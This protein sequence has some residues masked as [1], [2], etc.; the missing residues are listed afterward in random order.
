M[1]RQPIGGSYV[2]SWKTSC[3]PRAVALSGKKLIVS[4]MYSST[5]QIWNSKG[6]LLGEQDIGAWVYRTAATNEYVCFHRDAHIRLTTSENQLVKEWQVPECRGIAIQNDSIYVS[7]SSSFSIYSFEGNLMRSWKLKD[8][9]S[10]AY[11]ARKIAVYQNEIFMVDTSTC[12]VTVFSP[13]GKILREWGTAGQNPSQFKCPWGIAVTDF[14]VYVVDS[15]NNRIQAFTHEGQF[16]FEI[17]H[18]EG[19]DLAEIFAL[20]DVLYVSDWKA[21]AILVFQVTYL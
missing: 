1:A 3:E 2:R 5:M 12:S 15:G 11:N 8:N 14:V 4:E 6:E 19:Q 20:D 17:K 7:A 10:F 16:L 18:P 9:S 21:R 13:E